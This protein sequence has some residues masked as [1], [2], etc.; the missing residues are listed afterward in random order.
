MEKT[1]SSI[2]T[3]S[4]L[5]DYQLVR[6]HTLALCRHLQPEDFVL[7]PVEEVS[8]VKWHLA[9]TTWFFET[10]LLLKE[11]K[12]YQAYHPQFSYLFNSYYESVGERT[13]RNQRGAMSRPTTDEVMAYRQYVDEAMVSW[14]SDTTLS[15]EIADLVQLGLQHEQQHQELLLTDI[16]YSLSLNPLHPQVLEIGEQEEVKGSPDFAFIPEGIYEIGHAG[17]GFCFDNELGRH[18]VYLPGTAIRQQLVSNAEYQEFIKA[19]GYQKFQYWHAEAWQWIAEKNIHAPLYWVQKEGN[20]FHYTLQGLQPLKGDAPV[21][22]VSFYEASAYAEWAGMRLPTEFEWE[23]AQHL[24]DWGQ[25]WEWTNSAYLPYPGFLKAEGA[26]GEYNGK[27]MINQMVLR[28]ASIATPQGHS[29][30]SYRNFFHAPARWQ[31]SGIR[32]AKK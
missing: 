21:S 27:F 14:L 25:R 30:A 10:F 26:V 11:M 15:R 3:N 16:K 20:W 18:K 29:R 31:F 2:P 32:L 5:S 8:P 12:G 1:V 13:L 4:L 28:G 6:L 17:T 23:A 19:G 22:H 7:Q 24:F 9:H